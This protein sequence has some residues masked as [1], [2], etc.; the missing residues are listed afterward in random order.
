MII[1]EPKV[2]LTDIL[3]RRLV[4]PQIDMKRPRCIG[5]HEYG[6]LS[7]VTHKATLVICKVCIRCTHVIYKNEW[8]A[9]VRGQEKER[10]EKKTPP[11]R[12]IES[13]LNLFGY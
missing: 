10:A 7:E 2:R 9:I 12:V 1:K 4:N 6:P 5:P 8:M 11:I 3:L 13:H